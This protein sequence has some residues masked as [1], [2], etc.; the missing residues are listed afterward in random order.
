MEK[1]VHQGDGAGVDA[2]DLS[3]S[4]LLSITLS[5][6]ET[7]FH[8]LN[9]CIFFLKSDMPDLIITLA[10]NVKVPLFSTTTEDARYAR[11]QVIVLVGVIVSL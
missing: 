1:K 10:A 9:F 8:S 7:T 2:G 11:Q 4:A 5:W 6:Q 3:T